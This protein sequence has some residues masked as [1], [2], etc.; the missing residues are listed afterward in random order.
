MDPGYF[1][2]SIVPLIILFYYMSRFVG[3]CERISAN[4]EIIARKPR[5]EGK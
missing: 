3:A 1:L 5:D 4:L 2:I